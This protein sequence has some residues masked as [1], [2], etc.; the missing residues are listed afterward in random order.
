MILLRKEKEERFD[1]EFFIKS[2]AFDVTTT[3]NR[4]SVIPSIK[5]T[6]MLGDE[7]LLSTFSFLLLPLKIVIHV[8]VEAYFIM[9]FF[10]FLSSKEIKQAIYN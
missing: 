4:N 3:R 6:L 2:K 8:L 9:E 10:C 5:N 1:F 7:V